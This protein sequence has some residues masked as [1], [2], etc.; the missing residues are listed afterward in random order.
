MD[1][2]RKL[3]IMTENDE[4]I[5]NLSELSDMFKS[6]MINLLKRVRDDLLSSGGHHL[7]VTCDGC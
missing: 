4:A 3:S 7:G 5:E 6:L 2:K 1:T